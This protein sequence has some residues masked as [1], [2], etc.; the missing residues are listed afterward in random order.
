[1]VFSNQW[2]LKLAAEY[3]RNL[4]ATDAKHDTTEGCKSMFSSV[5]VFT[6]KGWFTVLVWLSTKEDEHT[7][8][9]GLSALSRNIPCMDPTCEHRLSETFGPDGSYSR[10]L[11]CRDQ[12]F[13]PH[14]CIDKHVPSLNA[15][16]SAGMPTLLDSYHG[17]K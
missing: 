13:Q 17:F 10:K 6:P 15:A 16:D 12:S 2:A 5:G 11:L 8:Y 7:I 4:A 3:G 1:M 9:A 14:L